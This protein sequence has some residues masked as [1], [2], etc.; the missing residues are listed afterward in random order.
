MDY[1][2]THNITYIYTMY[3]NVALSHFKKITGFTIP[4]WEF[5]LILLIYSRFKGEQ[6]YERE[7][8]DITTK[9]KLATLLNRGL[10]VKLAKGYSLN[11]QYLDEITQ[12]NEYIYN[13]FLTPKYNKF[14]TLDNQ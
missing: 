11:P 2:Q 10:V 5:S 13:R 14:L 12:Q 4:V 1:N 3:F 7:I 6:F 8:I 9:R